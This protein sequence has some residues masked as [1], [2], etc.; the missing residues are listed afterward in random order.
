MEV[1]S[2]LKF[3]LC[4]HRA[5]L[6]GVEKGK[7]VVVTSHQLCERELEPGSLYI[8]FCPATQSVGTVR[9]SFGIH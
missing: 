8:R 3:R 7:E 4:K 9:A 1:A 2:M 5:L 6:C